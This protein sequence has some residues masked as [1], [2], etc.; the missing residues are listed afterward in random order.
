MRFE[1][2]HIVVTGG[3]RGLGRAMVLAY[4]N[5]GARVHCTYAGNEEAAAELRE[6]AGDAR[7]RLFLKKFD[8]SD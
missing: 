2:Q 8:V 4:L 7:E 6:I 1:D 3:T 5:E